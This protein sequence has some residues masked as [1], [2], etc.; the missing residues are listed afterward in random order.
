MTDRLHVKTVTES[1]EPAANVTIK[2]CSGACGLELPMESFSVR[3]PSPDGL[4]YQCKACVAEYNAAH[5]AAHREERLVRQAAYD[6]EHKEES[7][8]YRA[9]HREERAV[10]DLSRHGITPADFDAILAEQGGGCGMCGTTAP[11]RAGSGRLSIDHDHSHHPGRHGCPVC[12]R[13]VLCAPCN[14]RLE[15]AETHDN[16]AYLNSPPVV[17]YLARY[18]QQ[19]M[20]VA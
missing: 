2:T 11:G 8:V 10:H 19:R 14:T 4:Q 15:R 20:Q 17:L 18:E 13:G 3:R 9:E 1:G 6:A 7:A 16:T 12:I 5:Y